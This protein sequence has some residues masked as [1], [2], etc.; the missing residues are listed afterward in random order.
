MLDRPAPMRR[1]PE[2]SLLDPDVT[3]KRAVAATFEEKRSGRPRF[4]TS[5]RLL[6]RTRREPRGGRGFG[7]GGCGVGWPPGGSLG[8][9]PSGGGTVGPSANGGAWVTV[10]VRWVSA[11]LPSSSVTSRPTITFPGAP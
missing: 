3:A 8:R 5:R 11:V 1:G 7:P 2:P 10:S 4:S 6:L 9:P